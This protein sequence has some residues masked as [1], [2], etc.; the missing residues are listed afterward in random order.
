MSVAFAAAPAQHHAPWRVEVGGRSTTPLHH[1]VGDAHGVLGKAVEQTGQGGS[2]LAVATASGG[3]VWRRSRGRFARSARRAG[4]DQS[5]SVSRG[6][7]LRLGVRVVANVAGFASTCVLAGGFAFSRGGFLDAS[8]SLFDAAATV[9]FPR[10]LLWQRGI[11]LYYAGRFTEGAE[12]FRKDVEINSEDTEE[13]IWAMLCEAR[14]LGF[15]AAR[16]RIQS[17]GEDPRKVMQ[18]VYSL[19]K[20]GDDEAA[21]RKTLE[22]L[23]ESPKSSD[24]AFYSALYLGLFDEARGDKEASSRWIRKALRTEYYSSAWF[25]YMCS[26]ATVHAQ[27]RGLDAKAA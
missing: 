25:D 22:A 11:S 5:E 6:D 1:A 27:E 17:V 7:F 18:T 20:G 26:V 8:I 21:S 24:A 15:D 13:A 10:P 19:F 9:G 3:A 16:A 12:Q 2:L 4:A 14:V 23:A